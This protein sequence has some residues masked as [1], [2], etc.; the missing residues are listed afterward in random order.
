MYKLSNRGAGEMLEDV[1]DVYIEKN[2]NECQEGVSVS[3]MA[4]DS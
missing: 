3:P 1:Q 4:V 2:N